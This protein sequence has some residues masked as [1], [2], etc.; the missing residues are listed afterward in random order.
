LT[1]DNMFLEKITQ[2]G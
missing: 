2:Q 1:K